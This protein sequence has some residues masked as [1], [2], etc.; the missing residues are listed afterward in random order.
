MKTQ[1]AERAPL[2]FR[3][4]P[5]PD[6]CLDSWLDR[7]VIRH[8][9]SRKALFRYLDVDPHLADY[10]LARGKRGL[11]LQHHAAF[12]GLVAQLGWAVGVD[13]GAIED[14]F[15]D[16]PPRWLLPPALRNHGCA[17]CWSGMLAEGCPLHVRKEWI[18]CASWWCHEHG[19]PLSV[20]PASDSFRTGG[21]LATM[22]ENLEMVAQDMASSVRPTARLIAYNRA[23][24]DFLL[25]GGDGLFAWRYRR[26]FEAIVANGF[27][28]ST[29]RIRLMALRH[30]RCA[31]SARRF[32]GFIAL[33]RNELRKAGKGFFRR[34]QPGVEGFDT[35]S[36]NDR[37][38]LVE[39]RRWDADLFS[40][41]KAYLEIALRAEA[42]GEHLGRG[43]MRN[44]HM[45]FAGSFDDGNGAWSGWRDESLAMKVGMGSK[46]GEG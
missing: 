42:R 34:K 6:E 45:D 20:M 31:E 22:L 16:W 4:R 27:H 15:V 26:Y 11:P 37:P 36:M 32:E 40:L 44:P 25:E 41:F 1:A 38:R 14:S 39:V 8:E 18:L 7:I 3:V 19:L 46:T 24:I 10:D 12:D 35:E 29:A 23:M 5:L 28:F 21:G 2:A 9:T 43:R 33:R 30:S 13:G 17:R